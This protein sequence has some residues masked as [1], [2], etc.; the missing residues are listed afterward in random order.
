M[1]FNNSGTLAKTT[2]AGSDNFTGVLNNTGTVSVLN[3]T[4]SLGGGGTSSGIFSVASGAILELASNF[5]FNNGAQI[6]GPGVVRLANATATT[7]VGTITNNGT[8]IFAAAGSP[9]DLILSGNVLLSGSG[10]ILLS[11]SSNDRIFASTAGNRLTIGAS[12]TIQGSG[13][14]GIGQTTFT[15]NGTVR[16]NQ[17]TALV[18]QP[19][20]GTLDF[21]NTSSG[22]LEASGGGVLQLNGAAGG[23]FINNNIVRALDGSFVDIVNATVT[24][25]GI[26]STAGTGLIRVTNSILS[27]LTFTGSLT[28]TDNAATTLAGTFTNNGT[29]SFANAGN[30]IDLRLSGN[31]TLAGT[32]LISL[33][34]FSSNRIFANVGGDRLTIGSGQTIQGSGNLGA[35][36]TTFTNNGTIIA[37]QSVPLVLQPGLG[38]AD[39]TNN[40]GGILRA[41]GGTLQLSGAGG[42]FFFNNGVIEALNSSQV[43][44]INGA[45]VIGG[46]FQTANGGSIHS[47]GSSLTDVTNAG[48]DFVLNDNSTTTLGGTFTNDGTLS[49]AN[50]GNGV[51]LRLAG[52]VMLNGNGNGTVLLNDRANNFIVANVAGDRFTIGS[53]QTILGSGNLGLGQ[54]TFTNNGA[55]IASQSNPLVLQPGGGTGDFT[56]NGLLQAVGSGTLRFDGTIIS[57][58][59]VQ[60]LN[61]NVAGTGT[62]T[63]TGG[64]F[65]LSDGTVQLNNALNIQAGLLEGRGT[66]NASI[67]S[68]AM[69]HPTLGAAGLA[70]TGNLTLLGASQLVFD[71]GGL[72]QG[73]Q[74]GFLSVN[75][76][77]SLGGQLLVSFVGG[78]VA[79]QGDSFTVLASTGPLSGMF[80]NV[81]SGGRL[82]TGTGSFLVNY[83]GNNLVLSNF[84]IAGS[85]IPANWMGGSGNWSAG[86]N[87]DINPNFPNNGQPGGGDRY[88]ATLANGGTITLDIPITIEKLTLASGTIT[89]AN[90]LTLNDLFTWTGG[91]MAGPGVTNANGGIL[92]GNTDLALNQ[93]TLNLAAGQSAVLSQANGRIVFSNGAIFN[94]AGTFLAQNDVVMF[95]NGGGGTFN[96]TGTFTRDTSNGTFTFSSGL[97]FNNS[98]TV[99][100]QSGTL[101]LN[102][103]DGGSTTGDFNIATGATLLVNSNF[104]FA[105]SSDFVGPGTANFSGGAQQFNGNYSLPNLTV[106]GATLTLNISVTVSNLTLS[107]GTLTGSTTVNVNGPLNWSG[108][109]MGGPGITN[110]NGGIVFGGN[111]GL[112]LSQRTLNLAVGQSAALSQPFGRIVFTNGAVFNN[113]GTFLAQN[114]VVMFNNG[115]GGTFN[116][117]GTFTRDTSSGTFTFSS[118]LAFNNSGTV[119][120]QS[121]TL[122]FDGGYTQTAGMLNLNGGNISSASALQIN[123][124]L[125][126]GFGTISAAIQ[127]NAM[128]RPALAPGGLNVTGNVSLLGSSQLVFNLGGLTQG[129]QYGFLNVN[130]TV[131]LGG[132]LVLSFVN[133]FVAAQGDAFTVLAST[134][135]LSGM[136]ANVASGGRLLTSDNSGTFLVNY[137]G[138]NIVLSDFT[139]VGGTINSMWDGSTGNWSSAPNWNPSF[140]PNNGN[141]GSLYNVT[142]ASGSVSQDIVAGVAIQNLTLNGGTITGP[143]NIN[144]NGALVWN[145]GTMSGTGVAQ[146][147]QRNHAE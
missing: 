48:G 50:A 119:N 79:A 86:S 107:G 115:G 110:A 17:S 59:T 33:N 44:L 84:L 36:Q 83:S 9:T 122:A 67:M 64:S 12:Q 28:L 15:N 14:L 26:Y 53:G 37:N 73:S 24:G 87:W 45:R 106:S 112:T 30:L 100:V 127:N 93:R 41:N 66:I 121:G 46:I 120:P 54:T 89:G 61:G 94:N 147:R 27:D 108:G 1:T 29:V 69:L 22:I 135:P 70:V 43:Q 99:N 40:S 129:S 143:G 111:T 130:G 23:I 103:G 39:F 65:L 31:V 141:N 68:N 109:A 57:S 95:D 105:A 78:F 42:S 128:L 21:T 20:G 132:Q 10:M 92:F 133:G 38:T 77:V 35:A 123:G 6:S 131:T 101:Q 124:G 90:N 140:V 76:N 113:A 8:F 96:N 126:T 11:D 125:L 136:F 116:N 75:G 58:G 18:L 81:A 47:L 80:A 49:F 16:A 98:G 117:T 62:Y 2:G 145:G 85:V 82:T 13:N 97:A 137:S 55:V 74:Y 63:Q 19:G 91:T 5:T 142:V 144:V 7:L 4:L 146:R 34:N 32:G 104:N 88:D 51:T 114:D 60:V 118:G 56:N 52:S 102:G 72:T 138:N 25:S 71:L 3:G 139:L 134:G